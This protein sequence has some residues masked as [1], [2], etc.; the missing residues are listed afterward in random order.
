MDPTG[1]TLSSSSPRQAHSIGGEIGGLAMASGIYPSIGVHAAMLRLSA[2]GAVLEHITSESGRL[3]WMEGVLALATSGPNHERDRLSIPLLIEDSEPKRQ[4]YRYFAVSGVPMSEGLAPGAGPNPG[5]LGKTAGAA[6]D[7]DGAT[8]GLEG[9]TALA[10]GHSHPAGTLMVVKHAH[11]VGELETIVDINEYVGRLASVTL[12]NHM[13]TDQAHLDP[14]QIGTVNP[15][16]EVR[17][18]GGARWMFAGREGQVSWSKVPSAGSNVGVVAI[19]GGKLSRGESVLNATRAMEVR[20]LAGFTKIP[21]LEPTPFFPDLSDPERRRRMVEI[22][23]LRNQG[24]QVV[25]NDNIVLSAKGWSGLG[26]IEGEEDAPVFAPSLPGL[27]VDD[28]SNGTQRGVSDADVTYKVLGVAVLPA[29]DA[30]ENEIIAP[31]EEPVYR[32]VWSARL[33]PKLRFAR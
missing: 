22:E 12:S 3:S 32:Y 1:Y 19:L 24:G 28:A 6:T 17:S 10:A 29:P 14:E 20:N 8:L 13:V 33:K 31:D 9:S 27:T 25:Y 18:A 2:S 15:P 11:G 26:F 23:A 5:M 7:S 21:N 4:K 16:V 30:M